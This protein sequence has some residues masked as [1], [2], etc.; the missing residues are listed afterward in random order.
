MSTDE[1]PD[2]VA[3]L[4]TM[5]V[6]AVLGPLLA[7][8]ASAIFLATGYGLRMFD[9]EP[10]VVRDLIATGWVFGGITAGMILVAAVS[11]L[12]I[13]LRAAPQPAEGESGAASSTVAPTRAA[14]L[15][16]LAFASFV[17]GE[18]RAHLREEWAAVLAGDPGNGIVLSSRRRMRYAVGFLWAALRMRLRDIAAPLWMPVDWLLSAESRT[19]GFIAT[20]VGAQILY[21]QHEDGLHALAT[22]GWGWC[23]GC[24]IALRLFVGWLRRIRGIELASTPGKARDE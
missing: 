22:E 11:L 24:G 16:T 8:T 20:A 9:P 14:G 15:R 3:G 17:A 23:A 13:A 21:V 12:R 6:V 5:A 1:R 4:G 18:R 7:G 2:E 19:H 10:A